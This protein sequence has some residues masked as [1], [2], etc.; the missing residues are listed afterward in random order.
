M[1]DDILSAK[2]KLSFQRALLGEITPNIRGITCGWNDSMITYKCYFHGEI[3]EENQ[4]SMDCVATEVVADFPDYMIDFQ[5]ER[6]DMP[7]PLNAHTLLIW[8]YKRK[9][10]S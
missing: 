4:E 3:S 8:V 7:E 5:C 9:E 6:L 10:E 2:I 1:T